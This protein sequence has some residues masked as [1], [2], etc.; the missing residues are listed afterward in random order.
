MPD[1]HMC[2][3]DALSHHHRD[4]DFGGFSGGAEAFGFARVLT[5][6]SFN[7][8]IRYK[9]ALAVIMRKIGMFCTLPRGFRRMRCATSH[10]AGAR[11]AAISSCAGA[12]PA[13][14]GKSRHFTQAGPQRQLL[15][16]FTN[17]RLVAVYEIANGLF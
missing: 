14:H 13:N 7:Y 6:T 11:C 4:G 8:T 16:L 17:G 15:H 1:P 12:A 9:W 10:S 5:C 2:H 3:F